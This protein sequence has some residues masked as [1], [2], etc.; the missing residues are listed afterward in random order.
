MQLDS[1]PRTCGVDL[2]MYASLLR[3]RLSNRHN[4][5]ITCG[6]FVAREAIRHM[7]V[8]YLDGNSLLFLFLPGSLLL[9]VLDF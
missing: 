8:K 2:C 3:N 5:Y 1:T 6:S 9:L 7:L 4:L